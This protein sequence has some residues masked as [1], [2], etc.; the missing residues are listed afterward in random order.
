MQTMAS[1]EDQVNENE[2]TNQN[3]NE[4]TVLQSNAIDA[5]NGHQIDGKQSTVDTNS[6][7][8]APSNKKKRKNTNQTSLN[9]VS[10]IDSSS[11]C[12]TSDASNNEYRIVQNENKRKKIE[13]LK[14]HHRPNA[15]FEKETLSNDVQ[16]TASSVNI[17]N[18]PT[19]KP[20]LPP[21]PKNIKK[22]SIQTNDCCSSSSSKLRTKF[23]NIHTTTVQRLTTQSE[24]LRLEISQL[25]AA[26]A[27]EQNA[28]R[29]LR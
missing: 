11:N 22:M 17:N 8:N 6:D 12:V 14:Q 25:K 16:K 26:L 23:E 9:V 4:T 1:Y 2:I 5:S 3:E 10:E 27:S 20:P 15:A 28:V 21:K 7:T 19:E 29:A 24:Q 18:I 13:I